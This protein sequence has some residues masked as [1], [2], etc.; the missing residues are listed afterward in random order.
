MRVQNLI[1][2]NGNYN[3]N[4]FVIY[5]DN[6]DI[7]FQSYESLVCSIR[8]KG[9]LGFKKVVVFGR[10]YD[11]SRTTMKHLLTFLKDNYINLRSS[12]EI[13]KAIEKGYLI[14]NTDVAVWYDETMK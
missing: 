13:R 7:E 6:G 5:Q 12:A 14:D 9:G 4:Q 8:F 11:Y 10:D 2:S 3:A 1:N